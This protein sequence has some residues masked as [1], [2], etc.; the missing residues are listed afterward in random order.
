LLHNLHRWFRL[1]DRKWA[2]TV[3]VN[4]TAA[5]KVVLVS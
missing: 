2:I 5:L 4:T 1:V 3:V